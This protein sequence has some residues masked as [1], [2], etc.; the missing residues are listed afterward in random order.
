MV[1]V[2]KHSSW[3]LLLFT[4]SC[5]SLTNLSLR[6]STPN[7][8]L[9]LLFLPVLVVCRGKL[10]ILWIKCIVVLFLVLLTETLLDYSFM[11]MCWVLVMRSPRA[12]IVHHI[13]SHLGIKRGKKIQTGETDR[14]RGWVFVCCGTHVLPATGCYKNWPGPLLLTSALT[15]DCAETCLGL[16][17]WWLRLDYLSLYVSA[18]AALITTTKYTQNISIFGKDGW[19]WWLVLLFVILGCFSFHRLIHMVLFFFSS[20]YFWWHW[21]GEGGWTSTTFTEN[22][23]RKKCNWI[24]FSTERQRYWLVLAPKFNLLWPDLLLFTFVLLNLKRGFST[25]VWGKHTFYN[26]FILIRTFIL[27]DLKLSESKM[28]L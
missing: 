9:L 19:P 21:Y 10:I 28:V 15:P 18:W 3:S 5:S 24:I 25:L 20:N 4:S 1:N 16:F 17:S 11:C 12:H 23:K 26:N 14:G 13:A 27:Q 6:P 2:L 22:K 7:T 8:C